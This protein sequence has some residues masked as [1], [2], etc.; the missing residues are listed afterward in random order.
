MGLV[1]SLELLPLLSFP[2]FS[3]QISLYRNIESVLPF[4][5]PHAGFLCP[6]HRSEDGLC[7]GQVG[8]AQ[9]IVVFLGKI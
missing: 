4:L 1:L 8:V 3:L 6:L 7:P 5:P 2:P 9:G